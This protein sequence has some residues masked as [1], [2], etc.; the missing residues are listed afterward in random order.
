MYPSPELAMNHV[1]VRFL[2]LLL[3]ISFSACAHAASSY[4][5][6]MTFDNGSVSLKNGTVVIKVKGHE[7]ARVGGDGRL[8]IGGNEVALSP[9]EQ[10]ALARYNASALAF[11]DRAK[12]LG[13]ESADFALHTL[14]QVFRS[15]FD[16]TTDQV[17]ED[18]ERGSKVI[19]AKA[20]TLCKRMDDWRL[21]QDAAA[22]AVPE[23]KPYAVIGPDDTK[24]CFVDSKGPKDPAPA[25]PD[26]SPRIPS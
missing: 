25:I 1:N 12:D 8:S 15:V 19:E 16:G 2:I 11:T 7:K 24:D 22:Q 6:F 17:G 9:Q 21:A 26:P 14:G 10:V 4:H 18:A 23:F 13:L 5:G 3:A 20:E